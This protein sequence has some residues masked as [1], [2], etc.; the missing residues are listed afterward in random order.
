MKAA[1]PTYDF[2]GDSVSISIH[3][4]RE[5][6]D[7][8]INPALTNATISIHA[9]R[10]GG[11]VVSGGY[12]HRRRISIHAAREGG[13]LDA[14]QNATKED[15]FQ[16]TPPVKAATHLTP[17]VTITNLISIHAAREGGDF[18]YLGF[19]FVCEDFNPRR[20]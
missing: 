17:E 11:D 13:D 14:I 12:A 10:E 6:G 16:S 3:A 2:I 15:V 4:A 8:Y 20:P 19:H 7:H 18:L 9:A 5:G 1:T